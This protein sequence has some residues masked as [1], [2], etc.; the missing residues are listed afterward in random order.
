VFFQSGR[1][2]PRATSLSGLSSGSEATARAR[3]WCSATT[4]SALAV[5]AAFG[6]I[7]IEEFWLGAELDS[8]NRAL[9]HWLQQTYAAA[10]P[11]DIRQA[12]LSLTDEHD[13]LF[14]LI[15][16]FVAPQR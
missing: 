5:L 3:R 2:K 8:P 7:T 16:E 11:R 15:D 4:R 14:V 10:V 9:T 12:V 13:E 6:W 1:T